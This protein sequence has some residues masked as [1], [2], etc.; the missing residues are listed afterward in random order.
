MDVRGK[1]VMVVGFARSG[2]A[3][4]D[5]L[6]RRGAQVTVTDS[7]PATEF[8]AEIAGLLAQKI[9]LELGIHREEAFLRQDVIVVSPGVPWSLPEL[10][11]ARQG[12]IP[13]VPEV[14]AA[15]WFLEGTLIGIT[16]TNGKTTTTALLGKILEAS[17]FPTFVGGNIGVPLISAVDQISPESLVVAELSSFQLEA[18]QDLHPHVAVMLNLTPNHLDRHASFAEYASAKAQIFR[19]QT[20][21]DYAVLNADD[22]NVMLL[23]P[24]LSSQKIF[25]SRER[26][27][28]D[29]VLAANHEVI[30][31]TGNLERVLFMTEDVS[32]RGEFNLE[33]ALAATAAA[34]VVGADFENI[35]GAVKEFRA[36][37]HRLE[38]VRRIQGVAFY[39]DS[40]A[41]SVDATAKALSA[42]DQPVHLILGGKDKGAPY[43]PLRPLIEGRVRGIY[44]IGAAADR[45]AEELAGSAKIVRSGDLETAVRQAFTAAF[46]G[47]VVLLSPAC[48]SYDQFHDFEERGRVFKDLVA[49]LATQVGTSRFDT[50][51]S[52]GAVASKPSSGASAASSVLGPETRA[53]AS[54]PGLDSKP[55]VVRSS[56]ARAPLGESISMYE[57]EA[58]EVAPLDIGSLGQ[59]DDDA[60]LSAYDLR[61]LETV[62]DDPMPFEF[63]ARPAAREPGQMTLGIP[64]TIPGSEH[65]GAS[66]PRGKRTKHETPGSAGD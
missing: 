37:E 22:A 41:T 13:V 20:R 27:I 47:E 24:A 64:G 56:G 39:N 35:R 32:L 29:G 49:R 36:V 7:R 57:V 42:F 65:A 18:I 17:G 3:T 2:R 16:G 11:A 34:C 50:G 21:E 26:N 4:A 62:E 30:Y 25:F 31:R 45:I 43:G 10:E 40:K 19:N 33:N 52:K 55:Q 54:A 12:G 5:V 9:G 66:R 46:S 60:P 53:A 61:P 28:S 51:R 14:E 6:R 48:A 59:F 63:A 44:L 8:S 1:R 15:S 58:A 38:Y 23:A